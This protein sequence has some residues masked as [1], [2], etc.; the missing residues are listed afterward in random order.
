MQRQSLKG[1][2]Y[3]IM[4]AVLGL[5]PRSDSDGEHVEIFCS[6][7]SDFCLPVFIGNEGIGLF[8][9]A[10][11]GVG[12]LRTA[13]ETRL[14]MI[15][16]V[17]LRFRDDVQEMIVHPYQG[18]FNLENGKNIE[19]YVRRA[20]PRF[21]NSSDET[22]DDFLEAYFVAYFIHEFRHLFQ[23]RTLGYEALPISSDRFPPLANEIIPHDGLRDCWHRWTAEQMRLYESHYGESEQR[24]KRLLGESDAMQI[25]LHAFDCW[26]RTD[27][28]REEK[29]SLSREILAIR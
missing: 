9:N 5:Y 23:L 14:F 17:P 22:S 7:E 2:F 6:E 16:S 13:I 12:A 19:G 25:Q 4:G 21:M 24:E 26:L 3:E 1:L 8:C 10:H 15:S 11:Q 27:R 20:F 28:S 18:V 29:F